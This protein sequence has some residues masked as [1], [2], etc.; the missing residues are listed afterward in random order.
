MGVF[1]SQVNCDCNK[2]E[3]D[4]ALKVHFYHG[5][6]DGGTNDQILNQD[7]EAF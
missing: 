6:D 7:F 1:A 2:D 5:G 4:D 3:I